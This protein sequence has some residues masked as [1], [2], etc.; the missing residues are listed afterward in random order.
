M[1]FS[2]ASIEHQQTMQAAGL[3]G[4][5]FYGPLGEAL[6]VRAMRSIRE[7]AEDHSQ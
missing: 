2:S 6:G 5:V 7:K 3:L 4:R 1:G